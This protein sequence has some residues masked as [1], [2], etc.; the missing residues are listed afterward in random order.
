[1][2]FNFKYEFEVVKKTY[3]NN[4]HFIILKKVPVDDK[5]FI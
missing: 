2:S 3:D 5:A 4:K 1:M